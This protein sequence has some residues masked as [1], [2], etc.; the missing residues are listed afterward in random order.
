MTDNFNIENLM[1]R[2][3]HSNGVVLTQEEI[4]VQVPNSFIRN[5]EYSVGEKI[6]YIYLWGY[7]INSGKVYPS[8]NKISKDLGLSKPTVIKI[9]NQLEDKKGILILNRVLKDSK[10]KTTNL[11]CLSKINQQNGSFDSSYLD[12][13][14]TAY[15]N[16][17]IY[18]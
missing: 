10:E 2:V 3:E 1:F 17:C 9:L 6:V 5:P 11:Y 16:K 14:K 13:L 7:G 18:I 15:P 4:F 12:I 8:Q